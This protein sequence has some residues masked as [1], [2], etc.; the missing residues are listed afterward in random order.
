MPSSVLLLLVWLIQ[1]TWANTEII[2][3][4]P[5][6][7][8]T[9]DREALQ[10]SKEISTSWPKLT[11]YPAD[12]DYESSSIISG[13]S[14]DHDGSAIVRIS[15]LETVINP[16]A[17]EGDWIALDLSHLTD[18]QTWWK[19]WLTTRFTI[20]ISWPAN[21][22]LDLHATLH[23]PQS[24]LT[25]GERAYSYQGDD[26]QS[27]ELCTMLYLHIYATSQGVLI[28]PSNTKVERE[29]R[30][31]QWI[32]D[33]SEQYMSPLYSS[34]HTDQL[35]QSPIKIEFETLILGVLP[36]QLGISLLVLGVYGAIGWCGTGIALGMTPSWTKFMD[37][38]VGKIDK[39]MVND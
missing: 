37:S 5:V 9:I 20:R 31:P 23:T 18:D 10:L 30:I 1:T 29:T 39:F 26:Y 34:R 15:S 32:L 8:Q 6:Y 38:V 7:C 19:G 33:L 27:Q 13:I 36:K 12:Q 28:P 17:D 4:G 22:P 35:Y 25:A 11:L 2:N 3:A 14:P 16:R 24:M 21:H